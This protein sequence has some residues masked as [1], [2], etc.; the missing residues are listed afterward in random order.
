MVRGGGAVVGKVD[1]DGKL[2]G[3]DLCYLFP[4]YTTV[5]VGR[6]EGGQLVAGRAARVRGCETDSRGVLGTSF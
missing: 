2:T 4:D 5:L 3:P 6:F 1:A